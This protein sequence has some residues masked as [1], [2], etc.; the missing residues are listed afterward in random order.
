MNATVMRAATPN[1]LVSNL[2]SSSKLSK[3]KYRQVENKRK[4]RPKAMK[5]IPAVVFFLSPASNT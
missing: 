4:A 5:M 2:F 1:L 3:V